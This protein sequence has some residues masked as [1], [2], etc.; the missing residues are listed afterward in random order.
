M[1]N[2]RPILFAF[3]LSNMAAL[4]YQISWSKEFSY[5]F[6]TSVYAVGTVLTCF[7]AGL[8]IGSFIFGERADKS[9]NPIKLLAYVEIGLGVF[10]L[11]MI[12]LFA[13]LPVPYN[14][15]HDA[16][17]STPFMTVALFTLSFLV[18]IIPTS[19]IGGTFPIMNK[20]YAHRIKTIGEDV[21][22]VYS[23]D[24]IFAALGAISAGFVLM[25]LIGI[26]K[27]IALAA[28]INIAAGIYLYTKYTGINWSELIKT[29]VNNGNDNGNGK[30]SPGDLDRTDRVVFLSF[31]LSGFAALTAEVV[32]TRFLSLTIGTSVYAL[33][34]ITTAFLV[35]LAIGSFIM[36]KYMHKIEHP[37]TT[38]AFVE[39]GIGLS[40]IIILFFIDKLDVPY[41]M[42]YHTF[43][44]FYPF[45][46]ALFLIVFTMI[47]I[48]TTLMGTT[49]PLVSKIISKKM[50]SIGTDIGIIFATN[51][52]GA[53]F[54]S[55]FASFVLI[56][57]IG[58]TKTAAL[59]TAVSI[60][61]AILL[62]A[63][64]ERKWKTKFYSFATI[65]IILCIYLTSI[66]INPLF[67][68]AYYHGTQMSNIDNW[69]NSKESKELIHYEEGL[70]SS[71]SV[72]KQDKYIALR[73]DGKSEASNIP[74]ELVTEYQLAHIPIFATKDPKD[75]MMVGLGGGF[76]LDAI[77]NHNEIETIDL[78]EINPHIIDVTK[79]YFSE[80]TNNALDDPRVNLMIDDARNHLASTDKKYDVI[81]SQPSNIWLS[82]EGGLFTKQMYEIAKEDLNDRGV[83]AQWMPLY[84]MHDHDF[85]IFL[86]TFQSVFPYTNLWIVGSDAII[87]GSSY[88]IEYDYKNVNEQILH[89][90]EINSDFEMMSDVLVT[91][92][93]YRLLYQMMIPYY[94]NEKL[95]TEYSG[96]II[97]TDDHPT[98]EFSTARNTIYYD[99]TQI[100]FETISQFIYDNQGNLIITPPF[101]NLTTRYEDH[102]NM[103]FIN[104]KVGLDRSWTE[105]ISEINVDHIASDIY[106]KA[107][108]TKDNSKFSILA[109]PLSEQPHSDQI[110]QN[111]MRGMQTTANGQILDAKEIT[112]DGYWGYIVTTP[113]YN[114][115]YNY[116]VSWFCED[117]DMLYSLELLH[118]T[119]NDIQEIIESIQC[120]NYM[121]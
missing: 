33:S 41:L 119:E 44:S 94:M 62:F 73:I 65:S 120:H 118:A 110:K 81:I 93:R 76:T 1:K 109:I 105:I 25:P 89:N 104:C 90:S 77:T 58:M 101:T 103:D 59:G 121:T 86:A 3:A 57:S 9:S 61:I 55:F 2:I 50:T 48:P 116:A 45:T 106:M 100:P 39:L 28:F 71:V 112:V 97:N 18:L 12:P 29:A 43:N 78:V 82:G 83:F 21:G 13:F 98:L 111:I 24:T 113:S 26:N 35:G 30:L 7:M 23:I 68:G 42:L 102:I 67:A 87:V 15:I 49:M 107:I 84:E 8:A 63:H 85:E 27:T 20:I 46:I 38:F 115:H 37:I 5:V 75:V 16:L 88:P 34:I 60:F 117:N 108:Y 66:T 56:P 6:G 10:A 19:L 114:E 74:L 69:T 80:Y 70:Y 32:W 72:V 14:I 4:I 96:D 99:N 79:E 47:L 40:G 53:I 92:G 17:E 11:F 51:T 91:H 64:S 95:I 36:S 54:G 52:F 22:I 31:F